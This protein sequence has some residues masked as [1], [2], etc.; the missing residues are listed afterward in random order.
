MKRPVL[1]VAVALWPRIAVTGCIAAVLAAS[2]CGGDDPESEEGDSS[3]AG[4]GAVTSGGTGGVS[5]GGTGGVSSGGTSGTTGGTGGDAGSDGGGGSG[6]T[7]TNSC[8]GSERA[9]TGSDPLI[10][11]LDDGDGVIPEVDGRHGNWFT[12]NDATPGATQEPGREFTPFADGYDG[13][14][15][16]ARTWGEGFADY[17]AGMGISFNPVGDD[18]CPLQIIFCCRP[19]S[20]DVGIID[21][22]LAPADE[23]TQLRGQPFVLRPLF[24]S[25]LSL[26]GG[27]VQVFLNQ[28]PAKP[29]GLGGVIYVGAYPFKEPQEPG[30][31]HS[32]PH[33]FQNAARSTMEL[34]QF[35]L[36]KQF[37]SGS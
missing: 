27:L 25:L 24:L 18:R 33:I 31:F 20:V 14:P 2:A 36:R 5:T 21:P 7:A 1:S 4:G 15:Y 29:H 34:V 8:T 37:Y 13:S 10:D 17:G 9:A 30:V 35:F 12:Y 32:Y 16:P 26:F 19:Y 28:A 3:G 6:G 11:N 22:R 23:E